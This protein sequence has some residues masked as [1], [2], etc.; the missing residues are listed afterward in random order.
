[1]D[2]DAA[3]YDVRTMDDTIALDLRL[4]SFQTAVLSLFAVVALLLTAVGLYGVVS[5]TV[6]QRTHEI[7]VRRA[8]GATAAHVLNLVMARGVLLS[9]AGVGIGIIAA[10]AMAQF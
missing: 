6:G 4:A 8:L 9:L 1:M 3:L 10:M 2:P 5:Y 7:G